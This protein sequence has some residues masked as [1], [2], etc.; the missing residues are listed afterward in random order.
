MTKS[1]WN[2]TKIKTKKYV[3]MITSARKPTKIKTK[4][5]RNTSE[6]DQAK[7][8]HAHSTRKQEWESTDL[9]TVILDVSASR[10][11]HW[12]LRKYDHATLYF[13]HPRHHFR[14]ILVKRQGE[15]I[16]FTKYRHFGISA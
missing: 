7:L 3:D 8:K 15:I 5:K 12:M 6:S 14:I 9:I 4:N 11:Q 10:L 13:G 2:S 1:H 16:V